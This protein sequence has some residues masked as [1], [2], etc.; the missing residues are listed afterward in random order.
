MSKTSTASKRKYNEK[1]YKRWL[2][3]L[4][5]ED[6]EKIEKLRGDLSRSQFLMKLVELHSESRTPRP[7]KVPVG[8]VSVDNPLKSKFLS[9]SVVGMPSYATISFSFSSNRVARARMRARAYVKKRHFG[10]ILY[11]FVGRGCGANRIRRLFLG[12]GI[13]SETHGT[14]SEFF[15]AMSSRIRLGICPLSAC[16]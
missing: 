13:L 12:R 10:N 11:V 14:P 6:F 9:S 16:S 5:I 7:L 15:S 8:F 2:V 3:D 1:T 4:R